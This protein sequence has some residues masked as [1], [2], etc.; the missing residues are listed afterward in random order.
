MKRGRMRN[1][2]REQKRSM[3]ENGKEVPRRGRIIKSKTGREEGDT[4]DEREYKVK[5]SL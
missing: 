2:T 5:V 1:E 3:E 4:D